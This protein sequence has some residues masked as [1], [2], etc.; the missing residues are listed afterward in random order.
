[1]WQ[2]AADMEVIVGNELADRATRDGRRKLA[3]AGGC[4]RCSAPVA[5]AFLSTS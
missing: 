2:L 4:S 5:G 3:D 1:M